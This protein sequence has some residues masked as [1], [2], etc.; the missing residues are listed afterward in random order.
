MRHK[1][2]SAKG[3]RPSTAPLAVRTENFSSRG[4]ENVKSTAVTAR[5]HEVTHLYADHRNRARTLSRVQRILLGFRRLGVALGLLLLLTPLWVTASQV[6]AAASGTSSTLC[7]GYTACNLGT[8]TTHGYESHIGSSYWTMYPGNNCTNYVAYVESTAYGVSTPTFNLGD[9]GLWAAAA[10]QNG[11][12]VNHT[13][14]VGSVAVWSGA[15]SGIPSEG[16]VAVVE[17]VGPDNSYIVISQQHMLAEPDGY[18]WTMINASPTLNQWEQWPNSFIHF[19]TGPVAEPTAEPTAGATVGPTALANVAL[20]SANVIVRVEPL[21]FANDNFVFTSRPDRVVTPGVLINLTA[22]GATG[23]YQIGFQKSSLNT[24]YVMNVSVKGSNVRVVHQGGPYTND[25]P[26]IKITSA[27]NLQIPSV[28]TVTLRRGSTAPT[29]S[30]TTTTL[31][32]A[33]T[34]TTLSNTSSTLDPSTEHQL[35]QTVNANLVVRLHN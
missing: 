33:T 15:S 5:E 13:P 28:I 27:G 1:R 3:I 19:S 30:T 29:T 22:G 12:L 11:V 18:D 14:S 34:T 8:F 7:S 23:T 21:A 24:Q 2:G 25:A 16:H 20:A 32:G 6:P 9:G 31:A 10:A 35:S 4:E 17:A 26:T